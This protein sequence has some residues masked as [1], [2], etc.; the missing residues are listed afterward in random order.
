MTIWIDTFEFEPREIQTQCLQ[1]QTKVEKE[2]V[3]GIEEDKMAVNAVEGVMTCLEQE[4][5]LKDKHECKC[6][7][8][9]RYIV[10]GK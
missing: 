6:L 3:Q 10:K 9:M 8:E 2:V 5:I 1:Q 7:R 4:H